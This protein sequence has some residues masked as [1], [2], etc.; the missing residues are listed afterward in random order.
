MGPLH[1]HYNNKVLESI[2]TNQQA[3]HRVEKGS[4]LV[5]TLIWAIHTGNYWSTDLAK[6]EMI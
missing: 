6:I 5:K 4:P 3:S 2:S 1:C